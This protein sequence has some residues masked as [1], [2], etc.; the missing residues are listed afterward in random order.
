[1]ATLKDAFGK[2]AAIQR[3]HVARVGQAMHRCKISHAAFNPGDHFA[4][5]HGIGVDTGKGMFVL[6]MG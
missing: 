2:K 1:M 3:R 6:G 4:G 5:A